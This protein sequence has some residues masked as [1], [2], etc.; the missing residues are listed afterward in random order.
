MAESFFEKINKQNNHTP[1]VLSCLANLSNDEVFT[2]PEVVNQML[3]MLPEELFQSKETTFLDPACK[4]GVF[5]REIAKRLLQYQLPNYQ[6]KMTKINSKLRGDMMLLTEEE[7]FLERLQKT[8]DHIF[9]N[10][11]FGIAITELTS[12]LSRRSLYCSKYP[13]G[14]YSI[15]EFDNPEGNI[16][17]RRVKHT[18]EKGKC[19]FCGASQGTWERGDELETHAYEFIHTIRPE[20]IFK[21]KFD[22][23]ISNPPYHLT[24]GNTEGNKSKAKSIYHKFIS[25]AKKLNP[26]YISMIV[27]SRWM[28]KTAEGI[29]NNWVDEMLQDTHFEIIHDYPNAKSCFPGTVE[30]KGGINYFLWNREH[31]GE[32]TYIYHFPDERGIEKRFGYL[33]T[34][35]IGIVIRDP[36]A[37]KIL[38]RIVDIEGNYFEKIESNFSCFVSQKDFFTNK[39]HL[40]SKWDEWKKQKDDTHTIKY[41]VSESFNKVPFGWIKKIDIP[42]NIDSLSLHKVYIPAA[43]GSGTDKQILGY[44]FYGEPNSVCS[45]TYL[46]IGYDAKN[47]HFTKEECKNIIAY[48]KTKFFRYL[49]SIKKNT[50][51][52]PRAV[53]QFVPM[54]DFSKPWTDAE[55]YEKYHLTEDEINFIESMI[56]PME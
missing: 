29:P 27:E 35:Q 9:K 15:T 54:Q 10:Q 47:H 2:P 24:L 48:I 50:Q 5:L 37:Y 30:I 3:D 28:T 19:T 8:I 22:V 31:K 34:N 25:S 39:T 23:I 52:G 11:L 45:Q 13:N 18:F 56:R 32:C 33:S 7:I 6:E 40:T 42:K 55:L 41:Y 16:R 17:F 26:R 46:V 53:Y 44:P 36:R 12:L 21:M 14:P 38:N 43:A 4:T 20:E 49:V 51:N 1:D